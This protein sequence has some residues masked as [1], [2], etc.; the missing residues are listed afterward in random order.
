MGTATDFSFVEVFRFQYKDGLRKSDGSPHFSGGICGRRLVGLLALA[1][2]FL[3][4]STAADWPLFLGTPQRNA[5][6]PNP[7]PPPLEVEW[8]YEAPAG[9]D[10][11]AIIV[12]GVVYFGEMDGRFHAVDLETGHGKWTYQANLGVPASG[13]VLD[14][15]VY[16]GDE[17]GVFHAV[18]IR[19]GQARWTYQA[20]AEI[21][22]SPNCL[23]EGILFGSY[24]AN[25]YSLDPTTGEVRWKYQTEDR[26]HCSPAVKDGKTFVT[27][28][29][30]KLRVIAIADGKEVSNVDL[31]DYVAATPSLVGD[32][33][34]VG[35]FGSEVLAIDWKQGEV[36]W[37]YH[38]PKTSYPFYSSPVISKGKAILGGRDKRIH[39][40]DIEAGELVWEFATKGRVDSSPVIA[41]DVLYVG[42]N[43][44]NLY[45]LNVKDGK[46]LW[47]FTAGGH[48]VASPAIGGNRLVIGS[49]DGVLYCLRSKGG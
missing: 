23:P 19:T 1:F 18:N 30:G 20:G 45:A 24:D 8:T 27:G 12:D 7:L 26:V 31:N 10:S 43:D 38:H 9:I 28:C 2:I 35:T 36:V 25:L 46:L 21:L 6:A 3:A 29:D 33:A 49:R 15:T 47:K 4:A 32:R 11:T 17:D 37:R 44:G 39:A 40:I 16:F 34:Y 48:I 41:G 22:S 14:D 13:C 42:S 5:I